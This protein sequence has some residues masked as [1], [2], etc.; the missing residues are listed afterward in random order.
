MK[1]KWDSR[2]GRVVLAECP[3]LPLATDTAASFYRKQKPG[4]F[5]FDELLS[6]AV[7]ALIDFKGANHARIAIVDALHDFARNDKVVRNVE[8]RPD[9]YARAWGAT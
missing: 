8:M 3:F 7:E 9:K 1:L 6:V 2:A 4:R 5:E